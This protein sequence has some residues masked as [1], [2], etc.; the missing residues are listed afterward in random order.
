MKSGTGRASFALIGAL[1]VILAAGGAASA[2]DRKIAL[3]VSVDP[4]FGGDRSIASVDAQKLAVGRDPAIWAVWSDWGGAN[5]EFPSSFMSALKSRGIVPMVNWQPLDPADT[6]PCAKWSLDSIIRGDH[7]AYIRQWATAAKQH[8]GTVLVR[9]AH[10]MNGDWFVWGYARC[11]NT[12]AKFRAAWKRVWKIFRGAEGVGATNVKFVWSPYGSFKLAK[13][14]PGGKF[15]D[16][17]GFTAFNWGPNGGPTARPWG[18]M[19]SNFKPSIRAI[20]YVT[21]KPLIAAEMGAAYLPNCNACDKPAYVR[22]GYPAVYA[23]WPRLTAIVYFDID[24][25]FANQPNWR[26]DSPSGAL[27]EYVKIANDQRFQGIIP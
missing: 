27:T 23:K 8:G 20:S 15:V 9:F 26:L 18:T 16:Y 6:N 25:A 10:E 14:Y 19:V 17:A 24:M 5:K 13:H 21:K 22:N 7:D 4:R 1:V 3:G 12:P 2:A 11:T